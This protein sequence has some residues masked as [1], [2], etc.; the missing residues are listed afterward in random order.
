MKNNSSH[1][2]SCSDAVRDFSHSFHM[3]KNDTFNL[4]VSIWGNIV[5]F[6]QWQNQGGTQLCA[7]MALMQI[8]LSLT[9]YAGFYA[10]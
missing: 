4:N 10:Y 3:T 2:L 7:H 5:Y 1:A 9:L 6:L 8:W